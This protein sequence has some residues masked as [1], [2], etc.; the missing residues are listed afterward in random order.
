[1]STTVAACDQ[2]YIY[3]VLDAC[4]AIGI[5]ALGRGVAGG[6]VEILGH[7]SL[8]A[9]VS[10]VD[11]GEVAQTRRNMLAHTAVLERTMAQA[12][13]LPVRFG[14]VAPDV[15]ALSRCMARN[16][17]TF[18][19]AMQTI[20]GRIELGVKASWRD[21]IVFAEILEND[22]DLCRLRDRLRDLPPSKTHYERGTRQADR[23]RDQ[24]AQGR[25]HGNAPR[26]LGEAGRARRRIEN[27]G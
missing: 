23:G 14:T 6:L 15:D 24:H 22:T 12:T 1:V 5:D 26:P 20:E 2:L 7:G 8:R 17:A 18:R 27:A 3:G 10:T 9:L 25:R 19:T 13:V 21:G 11:P 4:S 16:E